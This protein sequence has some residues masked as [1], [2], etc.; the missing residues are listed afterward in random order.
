MTK[1]LL[2]V[3]ALSLASLIAAGPVAAQL[4]S[5][6]DPLPRTLGESNDRRLDRM[7]QTS[8]EMRTI[9]F[10]GRDTG[11]P[12]VVQPA[13]TQGQVTTL[14]TRIVDL[15]ESLKRLN[16]QIDSLATDIA[17][18]RRESVTDAA[19]MTSLRQANAALATR[20]DGIDK[21]IGA[22][23]K[24]NTDRAAADAASAAEAA[25]RAQDPLVQYSQGM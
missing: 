20:L 10:Q 15:Q 5:L 2:T 24:A 9:L 3:L 23:N 11:R 21:S 7:E 14:D 17:A 8:R 6:T 1:P 4:D 12:V 16:T 19:T 18:L 13:E 22:L 25:Q